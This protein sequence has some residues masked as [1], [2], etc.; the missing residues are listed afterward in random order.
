MPPIKSLRSLHEW[1]PSY[2]CFVDDEDFPKGATDST[3]IAFSSDQT[4]HVKKNVHPRYIS[5]GNCRGKNGFE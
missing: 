4:L 2:S 3:F 5:R 1:A